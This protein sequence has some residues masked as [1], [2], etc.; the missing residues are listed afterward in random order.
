MLISASGT[1]RR[2]HKTTRPLRLALFVWLEVDDDVSGPL[3]HTAPFTFVFMIISSA[4]GTL[5]CSHK[6]TGPLR[7][8]VFVWLEVDD[9]VSITG[10]CAVYIRVDDHQFSE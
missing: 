8:K 9:D 5:R 2:S 4:S 7:Q 3:M 10:Y 1:L 6:T